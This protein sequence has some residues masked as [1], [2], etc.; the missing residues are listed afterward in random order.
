MGLVMFKK[1]KKTEKE[2]LFD[3]GIRMCFAFD[4]L[5]R[6]LISK[7]ETRFG[8]DHDKAVDVLWYKYLL[9]IES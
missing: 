7:E 9:F 5:T 4:L 6:L 1:K 2:T 3:V 8:R